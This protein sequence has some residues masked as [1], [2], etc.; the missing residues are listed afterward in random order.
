MCQVACVCRGSAWNEN[1]ESS[2]ADWKRKQSP[3][4]IWFHF[5]K[6]SWVIHRIHLFCASAS[7]VGSTSCQVALSNSV[8]CFVSSLTPVRLSQMLWT[9]SSRSG[10]CGCCGCCC[11]CVCQFLFNVTL[12]A[13]LGVASCSKSTRSPFWEVTRSM[14]SP[15]TVV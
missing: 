6:F 2:Q 11:W 15:G 7:E 5:L 1:L 12:D 10:C 4:V 14:Q 13:G 8:V 9:S 3:T